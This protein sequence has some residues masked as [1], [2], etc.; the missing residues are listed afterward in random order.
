LLAPITIAY[1]I[2][3][4]TLTL[5]QL[6]LIVSIALHVFK[7]GWRSVC[8]LEFWDCMTGHWTVERIALTD[9]EEKVEVSG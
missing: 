4:S 6:Q 8:T 7:D 5:L 2:A 3:V 9:E 1:T